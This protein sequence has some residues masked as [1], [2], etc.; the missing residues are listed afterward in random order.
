MSTNLVRSNSRI[1][2]QDSKTL[3]QSNTK[4]DRASVTISKQ[5]KEELARIN[6]RVSRAIL[7]YENDGGD[8]PFVEISASGELINKFEQLQEHFE[9][10]INNHDYLCE[11]RKKV[12]SSVETFLKAPTGFTADEIMKDDTDE[13]GYTYHD[14]NQIMRA[15]TQTLEYANKCATRLDSIGKQIVSVGSDEFYA[16]VRLTAK[17]EHMHND[18]VEL[19]GVLVSL[20][21]NMVELSEEMY[22]SNR[23]MK[24]L[25]EYFK[26]KLW[27]NSE[28]KKLG[29][30][31]VAKLREGVQ[32]MVSL[33]ENNE[34]ILDGASMYLGIEEDDQK[35]IDE[36]IKRLKNQTSADEQQEAAVTKDLTALAIEMARSTNRL[37]D[38]TLTKLGSEEGGTDK[39]ATERREIL[40]KKVVKEKEKLAQMLVRSQQDNER[41]I[42][43]FERESKDS[44]VKHRDE[45]LDVRKQFNNQI[46][47][48]KQ[49]KT[50]ML[51]DHYNAMK[52]LKSEYEERIVTLTAPTL[53]GGDNDSSIKALA[54]RLKS[55]CDL[56]LSNMKAAH[57]KEK[58]AMEATS[59]KIDREHSD[60][61]KSIKKEFKTLFSRI[62]HV[63][64]EFQGILQKNNMSDVAKMLKDA[65]VPVSSNPDPTQEIFSL[66]RSSGSAVALLGKVLVVFAKTTKTAISDKE[67]DFEKSYSSVY[68]DL[69]QAN[70][71]LQEI[72][73]KFD[74]QK[75]HN[76]QMKE[77]IGVLEQQI[78]QQKQEEKV[79]GKE[80][81]RQAGIVEKYKTLMA[82]YSTFKRESHSNSEKFIAELKRKDFEL[83]AKEKDIQ[84]LEKKVNK[85]NAGMHLLRQKSGND[86]LSNSDDS[87]SSSRRGSAKPGNRLAKAVSAMITP[88]KQRRISLQVTDKWKGSLN[89]LR[90]KRK[91]IASVSSLHSPL[92]DSKVNLAKKPIQEAEA[93]STTTLPQIT[94][95]RETSAS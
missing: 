9:Y 91:S 68:K 3:L 5:A 54:A 39:H 19:R 33:S 56:Q 24:L 59:Q 32:H 57:A 87:L 20:K 83:K 47:E 55:D 35:L 50:N 49:E 93:A 15:L 42:Q 61:I 88:Q 31:E 34:N 71:K 18:L 73:S 63:K 66:S 12:L 72:K 84:N 65:E 29:M 79:K 10:V 62:I 28:V 16:R 25:Y 22:T 69:N 85:L 46:A 26:E 7:L 45:I 94:T 76:R 89:K 21:L 43:A 37:V 2:R 13:G 11:E 1:S 92:A 74:S 78:D 8:N 6:E 95:D 23:K 40:L 53:D 44:T 17:G 30:K 80:I 38:E 75:E 41:L 77:K 67:K 14:E 27:G 36:E 52:S 60:A 86:S 58:L 4:R 48:M 51:Q 64:T 90:D 82:E 81:D 70:S